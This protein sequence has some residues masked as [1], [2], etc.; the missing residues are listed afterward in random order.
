MALHLDRGSVELSV[1]G[2]NVR[3]V[4]EELFTEMQA[5]YD[6]PPEVQGTVNIELHNATY[7]QALDELLRPLHFTYTIGPHETIFVH[8]RGTTWKPG[9]EEAA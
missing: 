1:A 6:L 8:K 2:R 3:E 7:Q 9:L 5:K 4:L